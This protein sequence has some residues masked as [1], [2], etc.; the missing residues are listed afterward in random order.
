MDLSHFSGVHFQAGHF[1]VTKKWQCYDKEKSLITRVF[2]C[3]VMYYILF[4][5]IGYISMPLPHYPETGSCSSPSFYVG[6]LTN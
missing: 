5:L 2:K 1:A 6:C 4:H 3:L